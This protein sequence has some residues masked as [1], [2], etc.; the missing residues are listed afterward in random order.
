MPSR[1]TWDEYFIAILEATALRATCDRGRAGC[2][3]TLGH[4]LLVTGYVGAPSG[5]PHCDEEGHLLV[6]G[7][8]VRT[9]HAEQNA[10]AAAARRG[11]P[12]LGSTVYASMTPCRV[13]AM[14]LVSAGVQR[15]VSVASY[16]NKDGLGILLQAGVTHQQLKEVVPYVP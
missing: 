6:Q 3:I 7:H 15:V 14:L 9:V 5:F 11:V 8:C 10:L 16:Q 13:C 2:V 12:L 1:P 4:D